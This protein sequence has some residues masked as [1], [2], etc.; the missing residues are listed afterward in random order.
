MSC[1]RNRNP[2]I[3]TVLALGLYKLDLNEE[4]HLP[5]FTVLHLLDKALFPAF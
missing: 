2:A 1:S 5:L 4:P 3:D